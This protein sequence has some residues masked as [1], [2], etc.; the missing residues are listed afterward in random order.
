MKNFARD[1]SRRVSPTRSL[2]AQPSEETFLA[3][4]DARANHLVE[5]AEQ[6]KREQQISRILQSL[7]SREQQIIIRRFG[8][9]H[10]VSH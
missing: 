5:E 9:N 4:E 3:T 10:H 7:D 8:L 2:S 6:L 1:N